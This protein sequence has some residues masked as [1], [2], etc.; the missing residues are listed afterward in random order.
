M[1]TL[2][3]K[4]IWKKSREEKKEVKSNGWIYKA[5]NNDLLLFDAL[6]G[7]VVVKRF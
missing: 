7:W 5:K 4:E 6:F 3:L 1:E 2:E